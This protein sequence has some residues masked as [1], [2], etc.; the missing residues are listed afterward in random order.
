MSGLLTNP[1]KTEYARIH[2]TSYDSIKMHE[3]WPWIAERHKD[4]QRLYGRR[5]TDRHTREYIA[6]FAAW[7]GRFQPVAE[8]TE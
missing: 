7:L 1:Y 3:Y 4:F 2:N 6:D 5:N 8:V